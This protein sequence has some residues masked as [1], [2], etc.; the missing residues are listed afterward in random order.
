[1]NT[2]QINIEKQLQES[3]LSAS[4]EN[5]QLKNIVSALQDELIDIN[6][7][8]DDNSSTSGNIIDTTDTQLKDEIAGLSN[9]L[10]ET[11]ADMEKQLQE[12]LVLTKNENLQ[13]KN[14]IGLMQKDF[15]QKQK[16]IQ[17]EI[18]TLQEKLNK[19][20][21]IDPNND[22]SNLKEENIQLHAI[23]NT[24]KQTLENSQSEIEKRLESFLVTFN[25]ENTLLRDE[26]SELQTELTKS[27]LQLENNSV[28]K[29]HERVITSLNE[30]GQSKSITIA[31]DGYYKDQ[32]IAS[33]LKQALIDAGYDARIGEVSLDRNKLFIIYIGYFDDMKA[34]QS[35]SK[36]LKKHMGIDNT[37]KSI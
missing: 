31:I 24:Y 28:D 29:V 17:N 3:F 27:K 12:T 11:H 22:L 23:I 13:L 2:T 19:N 15:D 33:R 1:L 18:I 34:A 25:Q 10:M 4:D 32:S 20:K 21:Q 8:N 14:E 6:L 16:N 26:I 5:L 36:K 30:N 7:R 35:H 37:I 9:M